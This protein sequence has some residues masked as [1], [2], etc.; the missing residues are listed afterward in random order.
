[1]F[2]HQNLKQKFTQQKLTDFYCYLPENILNI[3]NKKRSNIF[4]WRG[5]FSPQL[6]ESLLFSYCPK[7]AKILDPFAGS[8]TVLYE[9]AC[10]GLQSLG[11]EINP[12]AWILSKTYQLTNLQPTNRAEL[13]LSLIHI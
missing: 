10:L 11:C 12:A 1:M 3:E 4:S 9:S 6:I 7:N 8:G 5:Q 2:L 13:I